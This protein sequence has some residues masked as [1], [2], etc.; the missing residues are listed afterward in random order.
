MNLA[1]QNRVGNIRRL[2]IK[3]HDKLFTILSQTFP[4]KITFAGHYQVLKDYLSRDEEKAI[5]LEGIFSFGYFLDDELIGTYRIHSYKMNYG[6]SLIPVWGLGGVGV[7]LLYK[8]M[9]IAHKLL[10]HFS[11]QALD[12]NV[13]LTALYPFNYEFYKYFGYG[14]GSLMHKFEVSP[15]SFDKSVFITNEFQLRAAKPSDKECMLIQYNSFVKKQHGFFMRQEI[16]MDE[17][18]NADRQSYVCINNN[19]INGYITFKFVKL[20]QTNHFLNNIQICDLVYET[21]EVLHFIIAFLRKQA[22]QIKKIVYITSDPNIIQLTQNPEA[23]DQLIYHACHDNS[24]AGI[25]LMYKITQLERYFKNLRNH[26]FGDWLPKFT[27]QIKTFGND[28]NKNT[29]S[30]HLLFEQGRTSILSKDFEV[31]YKTCAFNCQIKGRMDLL[32]SLLLGSVS[33]GSL[34]QKGLIEFY[35]DMEVQMAQNILQYIFSQYGELGCNAEF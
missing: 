30:V 32:A 27:L 13:S 29:D 17:L 19:K 28:A 21:P 11:Q 22:D 8:K 20:S 31:D 23:N 9:K 1:Q 26:S 24:R 14:Y 4:G 12:N 34:L 6:G 16:A 3:D 7:S 33:L 35:A 25:A 18:F 10:Q 15:N 5:S 2:T